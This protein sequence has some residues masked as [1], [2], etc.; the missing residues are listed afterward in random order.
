MRL[1]RRASILAVTGMLLIVDPLAAARAG[2]GQV[3]VPK[4]RV[5]VGAPGP[6]SAAAAASAAPV[7]R[8]HR[9]RRLRATPVTPRASVPARARA[10]AAPARVR[11]PCEAVLAA[12]AWPRGWRPACAG[13]RPG[14]LG[15]TYPDGTTTLYVRP[16][17]SLATMHV[18][19]LHEA[20]H[21]WDLAKL[22]NSRID[23]W[24]AS[25]GCD[26]VHFFSGG[27][28]GP[29]WGQPGGAEDWA[30]VWDACHGGEYHRSYLGLAPP[31]PADC[32]L[33]NTLVGFGRPQ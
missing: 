26:G 25:R 33:Q 13:A 8:P 15:L 27:P 6:L 10:T 5:M 19:A 18:V 2:A 31:T 17:E 14:L 21:A 30:A 24:C 7:R 29:D 3:R 23:Q 22:D 12:V 9:A 1:H 32:A 16:D 4:A 11:T 20:G 28:G